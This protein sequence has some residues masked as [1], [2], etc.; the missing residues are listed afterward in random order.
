MNSK[1]S[2]HEAAYKVLEPADLGTAPGGRKRFFVR[3]NRYARF[4][5]RRS[6]I[7]SNGNPRVGKVKSH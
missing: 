4:Q 5:N 7:A 1:L 3:I 6:V 2:R